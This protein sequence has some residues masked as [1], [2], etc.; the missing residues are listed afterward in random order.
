VMVNGQLSVER[1]TMQQAVRKQQLDRFEVA[2][3]DTQLKQLARI[4]EKESALLKLLIARR[5]KILTGVCQCRVAA[6]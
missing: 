5:S 6:S 2:D 3:L 4:L 1:G